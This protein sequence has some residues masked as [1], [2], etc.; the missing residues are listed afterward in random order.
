MHASTVRLDSVPALVVAA[1]LAL[2]LVALVPWR[3]D[4]WKRRRTGRTVTVLLAVVGVALACGVTANRL[5]SFYPTLGSL[6]GSSP[7]PGEG[8]VAEIGENG[9]GL[10]AALP[11]LA[12]RAAA[13]HGST[14]HM[15]L[16]GA[17]SDVLRDAD[18]YLPAGYTDPAQAHVRYPVIE[19]LPGFPGEPREVAALFG[20]PDLIDAAIAAHRM[21]PAILIIPDINGEPRFGHDEEC[22]DARHGV[23]DDT[24]LTTDLRNWAMTALRVRPERSAWALSGWSSGGY[25]AMNLALR[26]PDLYS[27]AVSQSGYDITPDDIVTGDLFG[28]RADLTAANDVSRQLREHPVPL[29]ILA[30]AGSDE[31][32]EQAALGRI[33]AAATP[34]VR[35]DTLT[36]PGGGHN[37]VTVRAQLP[38]L[39]NWLG[40]H[41]VGP[42][43]DAPAPR[44]VVVTDPPGVPA[45]ILPDPNTPGPTAG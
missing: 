20:V 25:C 35:L 3:W 2:L 44:G 24:Y 43:A 6:I 14:V 40:Q 17:R 16:H 45:R 30:T 38:A 37:Q 8:T 21:P 7:N 39:V 31:T 28:G 15:T 5:G 33:R 29:A 13:G 41:M 19:W 32:D 22:V 36:F 11:V 42:C 26:H 18:V 34:P 23:A 10:A 1:V 4:A 9:V 27:I 12:A